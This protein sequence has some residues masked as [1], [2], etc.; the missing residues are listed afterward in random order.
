MISKKVAWVIWALLVFV[1]S[2][3]SANSACAARMWPYSVWHGD[4]WCGIAASEYCSEH[5]PYFALHPPVHY[6]YSILKACGYGQLA[7]SRQIAR[8]SGRA[9][10]PVVVVNLYCS[11]EMAAEPRP[12]RMVRKPLRIRNPYVENADDSD[13]AQSEVTVPQG[14]LLD[15]V[16][17]PI[18]P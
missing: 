10:R 17:K 4:Y 12:A 11:D 18:L 6:G 13:E 9:P 3:G 1:G 14:M 16:V 7:C 2:L 8:G 5:V 15:P